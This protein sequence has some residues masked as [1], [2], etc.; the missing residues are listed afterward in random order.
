MVQW[1][2]KSTGHSAVDQGLDLSTHIKQLT[3]PWTLAP[4]DLMSSC[5]LQGQHT[6]T[7]THTHTHTPGTLAPKDLMSSCGLQGQHTQDLDFCVQRSLENRG[8][9]VSLI[10]CELWSS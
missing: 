3:H 6:H 8:R 7:Q 10:L 9:E 2:G 5:G 4:K 1:L